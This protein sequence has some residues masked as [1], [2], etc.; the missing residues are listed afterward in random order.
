MKDVMTLDP[1]MHPDKHIAT[2]QSQM[3]YNTCLNWRSSRNQRSVRTFLPHL[4]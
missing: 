2:Q 3:Q 4:N 1:T